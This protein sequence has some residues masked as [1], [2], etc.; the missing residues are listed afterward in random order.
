MRR[1]PPSRAADA[2]S[3]SAADHVP[4][5]ASE[6]L[7]LT[8]SEALPETASEALPV[9]P[10]TTEQGPAHLNAADASFPSAADH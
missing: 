7:P 6:T 10:T 1:P 3:P 9:A 4:K 2:S 8:A 5:M